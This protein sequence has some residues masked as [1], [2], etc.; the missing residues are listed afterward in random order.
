MRPVSDGP[1]GLAQLEQARHGR[2]FVGVRRRIPDIIILGP[3]AQQLV[4]KHRDARW[5]ALGMAAMLIGRG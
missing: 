4:A 5:Q 2:K 3:A 1:I